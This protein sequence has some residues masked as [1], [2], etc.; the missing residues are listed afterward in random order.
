MSM[1]ATLELVREVIASV[2][3][4]EGIEAPVVTLNSHV[5][6]DL[7]LDSLLLM[8]L[9]AALEDRLGVADLEIDLWLEEQVA[10]EGGL[11]VAALIGHVNA[12]V[13]GA[14]GS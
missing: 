11:Q 8:E 2:L 5:I 3:Q 7:G 6:D 13:S 9:A 12:H 4:E 1:S 10:H 14:V